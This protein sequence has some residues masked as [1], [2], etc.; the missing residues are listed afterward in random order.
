MTDRTRETE[1]E[2]VRECEE[3]REIIKAREEKIG[4]Q[5][6]RIEELLNRRADDARLILRLI[7][8]RNAALER[9]RVAERT[10]LEMSKKA[11][12]L[13]SACS[14]DA[15]ELKLRA[16]IEDGGTHGI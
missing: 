1:G 12:S 4:L 13:A 3:Y 9:A 8:E 15:A 11:L 7:D 5:G 6:E 2:T 16:K 14:E 10:V